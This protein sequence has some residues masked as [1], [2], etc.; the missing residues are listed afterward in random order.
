VL[1]RETALYLALDPVGFGA[2]SRDLQIRANFNP[3]FRGFAGGPTI[4]ELWTLQAALP[5]PVQDQVE[6]GRNLPE[7]CGVVDF[8]QPCVAE[9]RAAGQRVA[10]G[11]LDSI[12]GAIEGLG[13]VVGTVVKTAAPII[14]AVGAI[15]QAINGGSGPVQ[16]PVWTMDPSMMAGMVAAG[17]MAGVQG[18]GSQAAFAAACNADP[19]GACQAAIA[20]ALRGEMAG[21]VGG[22]M[23]PSMM[24]GGDPF[25]AQLAGLGFPPAV[26]QALRNAGPSA[27][28]ALRSLLPGVAVGVGGALLTEAATGIL[29]SAST[30]RLP[31]SI[32]VPDP[33]RPGATR[34]YRSMGRPVLYSRDISTVKRVQRVAKRARSSS[35]A[36]RRP[37]S[38]QIMLGAGPTFCGGC[39][40][41]SCSCS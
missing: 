35:R 33:R 38:Q 3:G 18:S 17:G 20:A 6:L 40:K 21:A 27:L 25:E 16:G 23:T 26:I 8:S 4:D 15:N 39:G 1:D 5:R 34:E 24:N 10:M 30:G 11:F 9:R 7:L 12:T 31:T 36:R 13:S 28:G 37:A 2:R 32:F 22:G 41:S 14:G 29:P 19:T